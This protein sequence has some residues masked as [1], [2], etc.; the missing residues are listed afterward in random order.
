MA[1]NKKQQLDR[2]ALIQQAVAEIRERNPHFGVDLP[3]YT[4]AECARI[5]AIDEELD[6]FW[7]SP[8]GQRVREMHY[9]AADAV[10]ED[11][12]E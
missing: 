6:R 4:E 11:R 9:S 8:E 12:G 3:P 5:L 7:N 2:E 1:L 10:N